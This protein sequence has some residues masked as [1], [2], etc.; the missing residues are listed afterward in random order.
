M[1][2]L[3]NHIILGPCLAFFIITICL[4]LCHTQ[5]ANNAGLKTASGQSSINIQSIRSGS[6]L[7]R[8][9]C[10]SNFEIFFIILV[11]FFQN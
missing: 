4:Q 3:N 8:G 10:N 5:I 11:V 6:D 2:L 1:I 7:N 9:K